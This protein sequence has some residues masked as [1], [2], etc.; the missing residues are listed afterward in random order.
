LFD[1]V[2]LLALEALMFRGGVLFGSEAVRQ[3]WKVP[4]ESTNWQAG[5]AIYLDEQG[6]EH[7]LIPRS[8]LRSR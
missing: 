8:V 1:R 3:T 2:S 6:N 5:S 7:F 4:L